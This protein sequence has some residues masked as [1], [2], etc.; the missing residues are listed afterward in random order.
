[1]STT[2]W[3]KVDENTKK[4]VVVQGVSWDCLEAVRHALTELSLVDLVTLEE[5]LSLESGS[6]KCKSG[7]EIT[8]LVNEDDGILVF[9]G[10]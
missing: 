9:D 1:M 2:V 7:L 8:W 4:V 3:V 10:E 6:V 5:F